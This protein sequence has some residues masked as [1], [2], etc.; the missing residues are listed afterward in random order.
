MGLA[1]GGAHVLNYCAKGCF[2]YDGAYPQYHGVYL[3]THPTGAQLE[4]HHLICKANGRRNL[5]DLQSQQMVS[6]SPFLLFFL[7]SFSLS[8]FLPFFKCYNVNT[9]NW[10]RVS[11]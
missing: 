9:I 11:P 4:D 7:L 3:N 6:L 8:L 5:G 1:Y 10:T 2:V